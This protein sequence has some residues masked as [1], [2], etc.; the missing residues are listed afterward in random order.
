[1]KLNFLKIRR[2]VCGTQF[3]PVYLDEVRGKGRRRSFPAKFLSHSGKSSGVVPGKGH[4][5]AMKMNDRKDPRVDRGFLE[6]GLESDDAFGRK[7]DR[8]SV[9]PLSIFSGGCDAGSVSKRRDVGDLL[10]L[11]I[12]CILLDGDSRSTG[13]RESTG[14]RPTPLNGRFTPRTRI[15]ARVFRH[16]ITQ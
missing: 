2:T 16:R 12:R 4:K 6:L 3:N 13:C 9:T 15:V 7:W 1:M 11:Y 10:V 5:P 14:P 8:I